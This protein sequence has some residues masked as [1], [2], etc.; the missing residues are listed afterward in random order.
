MSDEQ[1]TSRRAEHAL[2]P[3]GAETPGFLASHAEARPPGE[4][5]K[6]DA[7]S[8]DDIS[9][10]ELVNILLR[11]WR[12]VVGL[13]LAAALLS[14]AIALVLPPVYTATTSFVPESRSPSRL[15]AVLA[16]L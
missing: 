3:D 10:L 14:A 6:Y 16:G 13:P 11:R 8:S 2:A 7:N 15:P 9:L 4:R 5:S 12:L 1:K